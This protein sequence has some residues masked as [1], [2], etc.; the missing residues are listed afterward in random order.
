MDRNSR[1]LALALAALCLL[2]LPSCSRV[3]AQGSTTETIVIFRHGEKP[4]KG[5]GQLTCRGL[6]RAL[7]LPA[8]LD[9]KFGRPDYLFAPDPAVQVHDG[10]FGEYSYVRPLATIEPTAIRLG[11]NVNA[12][13]GYTDIDKLEA[14]LTQPKYAS[15]KIFVAWEHVYEERLTKHLL[16]RF[17]GDASKVPSWPNS[18]FDMIYVVRIVRS[19]GKTTATFT[20]DH[21]GLDN[22]LSDQCPVR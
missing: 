11:M 20:L 5:L 17:G 13:I 8:V 18:E 6:N 22:K 9:A 12:Q 1:R 14:E 16:N 15:A 3:G 2:A 10:L 4:E 19:G 21:E 7:A